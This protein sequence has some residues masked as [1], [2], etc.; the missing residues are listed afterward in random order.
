[1]VTAA[2]GILTDW[3]TGIFSDWYTGGLVYWFFLGTGIPV[4]WYTDAF[5]CDWYTNTLVY[6]WTGILVF[7]KKFYF[8]INLFCSYTWV[9]IDLLCL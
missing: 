7:L 3:Y 5:W 1:M 9:I 4:D 6:R 8:V 2:T